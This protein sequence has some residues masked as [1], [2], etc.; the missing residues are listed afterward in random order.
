M[1]AVGAADTGCSTCSRR[2]GVRLPMS[3]DIGRRWWC[4]RAAQVAM[5]AGVSRAQS[6]RLGAVGRDA[7]DVCRQMTEKGSTS[8]AAV[9][10]AGATPS[11]MVCR[12]IA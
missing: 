8:S 11:S 3:D 9:A 10:K 7:A 12:A 1:P 4:D 6:G 5:V 2:A